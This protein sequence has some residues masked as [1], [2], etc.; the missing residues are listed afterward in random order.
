MLSWACRVVGRQV[1]EICREEYCA[2]DEK[3]G[4][5]ILLSV[6]EKERIFLDC[7]QSYYYNS[8]SVFRVLSANLSPRGSTRTRGLDCKRGWSPAGKS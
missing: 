4:E 7:I 3:T 8:R 5:P 1:E 2:R 6:K